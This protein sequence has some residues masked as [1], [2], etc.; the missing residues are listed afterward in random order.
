MSNKH[1]CL[2]AQ[3]EAAGEGLDC[4]V[5]VREL[6]NYMEGLAAPR[7]RAQIEEHVDHCT[8]CDTIL[9]TTRMMLQLVGRSMGRAI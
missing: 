4:E 5:V 2:D 3:D 6:T 8:D 9:S 7:L 1:S